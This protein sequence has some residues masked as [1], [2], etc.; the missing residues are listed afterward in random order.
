RAQGH[1]VLVDFTAAWCVTCL[2]N[3]R[4]VL[5]QPQIRAEMKRLDVSAFKGDWTRQDP[6]ISAELAKFGRVGVPL[7]LLYPAD[8]EREALVLAEILT[9]SAVIDGLEKTGSSKVGSAQ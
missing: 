5:D 3:E 9:A 1:P 8:A 4:V 7:Y 2:V 6:M